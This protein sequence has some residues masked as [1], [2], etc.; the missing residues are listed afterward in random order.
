[1]AFYDASL[2]HVYGYLTARCPTR[3][4]AEEITSEVFLA[5]VDMVR[6]EPATP[7]SIPWAVGIARH[8]LVDHWRRESRHERRL[9]ALASETVVGE[10]GDP[11]E[12]H[13]DVLRS[14]QV[15]DELTPNHKTVLMLRYL[16]D[17]AV[18]E[19]AKEIGR[20]VHATEA[21]LSRAK[22]AFRRVYE[23]EGD[24]G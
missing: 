12:V 8:K 4:T 22:A 13:L 2:P 19:V 24:D 21:L 15:L 9:Q 20:T 14:R 1:M 3:A 10:A 6:R 11:W 18:P 7:M 5:A 16:D 17:L 23:R